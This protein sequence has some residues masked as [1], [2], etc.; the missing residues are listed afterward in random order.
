MNGLIMYLHILLK[1]LIILCTAHVL[2]GVNQYRVK[3]KTN[4]QILN[5]TFV[6]KLFYI[7]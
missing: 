6:Q 2:I 3:Q 4:R 7:S 5:R 1:K